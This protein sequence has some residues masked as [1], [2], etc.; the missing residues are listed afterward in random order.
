M[1]TVADVGGATYPEGR[2]KP[3]EG[4][5][6]RPA[7]AGKEVKR[8]NMLFWEHEENRAVR[9][10]KWKLVAK[11]NEPWEL[12]NIDVDRSEQTNLAAKEPA[13]AKAMATAWDTGQNAPT[14]C[15]SAAGATDP[16]AVGDGQRRKSSR[17]LHAEK[18]RHLKRRERARFAE[19]CLYDYGPRGNEIRHGGR[20]T[21]AGRPAKR[22]FAVCAGQ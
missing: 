10:D 18:R 3:M 7:F 15:R 19:P 20:H 21:R 14:C 4:V 1:A 12:Y 17:A 5:S 16:A 11:A 22:D 8:G 6:L 2:I 13:R 9:D